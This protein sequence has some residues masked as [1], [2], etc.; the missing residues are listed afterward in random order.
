MKG[1]MVSVVIPCRNEKKYIAR[2]L[3]SFVNCNY[4]KEN[5]QVMVCDGMSDDGTIEIIKDYASRFPFIHFVENKQKLTPFAMNLG[6]KH[7]P[8]DYVMIMSAHSEID[9]DYINVCKEIL[10][11]HPEMGCIG[12]VTSNVFE[13]EQ[14]EVIGAAMSSPFGVG[15]AHFRTG[16]KEG[17]LDTV[18]I[19][20]YKKET[21][22]K[23]GLFNEALTRNQD[24]ELNYRVL[25]AGYKIFFTKRTGYR[26]YVRASLKKL[27]KQYFQYGYWKVYVNQMHK[28]V[29]NFR[30]LVPLGFVSFLYIGLVLSFIIPYFYFAYTGML[31]LYLLM[32]FTF[33]LKVTN[34]NPFKVMLAFLVLHYSYGAGY[35]KG[36]LHFMLLRKNPSAKQASLSR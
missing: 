21:L 28:T 36:I 26:Y 4:P 23:S 32:S 22:E 12:G 14:S 31:L 6:I 18:G 2:C 11:S 30:Q 8:Y 16:L 13:D 25:K 24:D 27:Y 19:P 29:T 3:D 35:L 5:L 10:D 1:Q 7:L 9:A 15:S 17:Y 33:A 34:G 20:L